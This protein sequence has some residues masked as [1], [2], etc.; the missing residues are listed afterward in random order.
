MERETKTQAF[1]IKDIF[2]ILRRRRWLIV[3]PWILAFATVFAGSYFLTP[4]YQAFTIVLMDRETHLSGDI[5]GLL[6]LTRGYQ[7]NDARS[8]ELR[9]YGNEIASTSY[10][11]QLAQRLHLDNDPEIVKQ[12]QNVVKASPSL[13]LD[14]AKL[15]LLQTKITSKI[16]LKWVGSDQIQITALSSTPTQARDIATVLGELFVAERL[17][18]DVASV[19]TSQD[20]SDVQLQKYDRILQDKIA[21]R[22]RFEK[23]ILEN[24]LDSSVVSGANRSQ[25]QLE[26]DQTQQDIA[27]FQTQEK[28]L[29]SSLSSDDNTASASLQLEDSQKNRDN[30]EALKTQLHTLADMVLKYRWSDPQ[31]LNLQLK[32]RN[33]LTAIA[34]ENDR[35]VD[36]QFASLRSD[37]RDKISKL[38]SVRADLDYFV[39]KASVLKVSLDELRDKMKRGPEHQATLDSLN[40]EIGTATDLS[41]RFKRQEQGST[42]SQDLLQDVASTKYRIVEPAKL[43]LEPISPDRPKLVLLG[44]FLGLAIGVAAAILAEIFDSSFKKVEEVEAMLGLPVLGIAPKIEYMDRFR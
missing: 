40:R 15:Y 31:V 16:T 33:L 37:L 9:G 39:S 30:K 28:S 6:G 17:R 24:Q 22:T 2:S 34:D 5:Q 13:S 12:A 25:I 1:D 7:A 11:S 36:V 35:L 3:I 23:F 41:N 18:R 43:P 8:E 29:L 42:I 14:Q 38:F 4:V 19:R 32:Q 20:F 26:I 10:I 44:V 21:E 27:D